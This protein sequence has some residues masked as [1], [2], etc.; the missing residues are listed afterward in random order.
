MSKG[1]ML[2]RLAATA[3]LAP[4]GD[5]QLPNN[6][7]FDRRK[8]LMGLA[9]ATAVPD[10]TR[11]RFDGLLTLL[12]LFKWGFLSCGIEEK[13]NIQASLKYS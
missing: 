7:V 1:F 5:L 11:T 2:C 3:M 10:P 4:S 9:T 12:E 8:F 13:Q 6:F